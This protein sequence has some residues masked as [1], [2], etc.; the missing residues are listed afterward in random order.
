M[1]NASHIF[2][3]CRVEGLFVPLIQNP[4]PKQNARIREKAYRK[5]IREVDQMQ[6][7]RVAGIDDKIKIVASNA[8]KVF[9]DEFGIP[10]CKKGS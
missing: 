1:L 6:W 5:V 3:G 9:T 10:I 8:L 2:A 7:E 4:N